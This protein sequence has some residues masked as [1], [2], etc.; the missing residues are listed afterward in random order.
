MQDQF[1]QL[2]S[3]EVVKPKWSRDLLNMRVQEEHLIKQRNFK[4]AAKV[5]APRMSLHGAVLWLGSEK[6]K[7]A[8]ACRYSLVSPLVDFALFALWPTLTKMLPPFVFAIHT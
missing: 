8:R 6:R 7:T 1:G 3:M 4:V 2:C 5:C